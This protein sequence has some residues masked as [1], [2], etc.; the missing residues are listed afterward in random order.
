MIYF[1][2]SIIYTSAA[3]NVENAPAVFVMSFRTLSGFLI[4]YCTKGSILV[5]KPEGKSQF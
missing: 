5:G 2:V 3:V 1:F 4:K